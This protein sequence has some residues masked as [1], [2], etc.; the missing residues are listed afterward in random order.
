MNPIGIMQG[1]LSPA[2]DGR[3]QSFPVET[4]RQ[5]FELARQAGCAAWS[6][7]WRN[8][9]AANIAEAHALGL[10][11]IPWTVNDPVEMAP[12][13]L[14]RRRPEPDLD[15]PDNLLFRHNRRKQESGSERCF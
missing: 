1:R 13:G 4:W 5:E 3:I 12:L 11:V 2:V 10:R 9:T 7:F 14:V 8:V 6:P 15:N